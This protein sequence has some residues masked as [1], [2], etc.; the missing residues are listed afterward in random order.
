MAVPE[1]WYTGASELVKW[2]V[3]AKLK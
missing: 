3:F 2:T 1:Y